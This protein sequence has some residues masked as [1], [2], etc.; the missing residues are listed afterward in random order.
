MID[1]YKIV[2]IHGDQFKEKGLEDGKIEFCGAYEEDNLHSFNLLTYAKEKFSEMPI[3]NQLNVRH[4]PE[5]IAYFLTKLG[6]M[7]FLNSTKY[8]EISLKKYGRSGIF[9]MPDSP[10]EKQ[11]N[12]LLELTNTMSSFDTSINY[13]LLMEDGILNSKQISNINQEKPIDL[14]NK[15]LK[16]INTKDENFNISK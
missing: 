13:N 6:I 7:V 4:Q 9:L 8:D 14:A 12:T 3:F 11:Q 1:K 10:T 2:F 16:K 15:Y 5:V